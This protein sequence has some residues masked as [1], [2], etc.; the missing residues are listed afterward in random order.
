M[1]AVAFSPTHVAVAKLIIAPSMIPSTIKAAC[2]S[3]VTAISPPS[4]GRNGRKLA[5]T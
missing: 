2:E 5:G 4:S 1:M 3:D